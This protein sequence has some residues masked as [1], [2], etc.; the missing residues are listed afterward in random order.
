MVWRDSP[1]ALGKRSS[2]RARAQ[3]LQ[4]ELWGIFRALTDLFQVFSL[5]LCGY[6]VWALPRKTWHITRKHGRSYEIMALALPGSVR[7]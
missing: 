5:C 6:A 2:I 4:G 3:E 7:E 1:V